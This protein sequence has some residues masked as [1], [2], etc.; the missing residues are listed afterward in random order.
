LLFFHFNQPVVQIE[1]LSR[2]REEFWSA[3]EDMMQQCSEQRSSLRTEDA[4]KCNG[5]AGKESCSRRRKL[6]SGW[7]FY[8]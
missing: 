8:S 4:M 7:D 6:E 3:K 2:K 1:G 5:V